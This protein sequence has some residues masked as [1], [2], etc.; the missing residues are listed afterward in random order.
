MIICW[1]EEKNLRVQP[2]QGDLISKR[3]LEQ[4]EI[5]R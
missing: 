2:S 4:Y 3:K 1:V 5:Q